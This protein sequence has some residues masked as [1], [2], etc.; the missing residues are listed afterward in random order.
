[1][2]KKR[3]FNF[4]EAEELFKRIIEKSPKYINA[5]VNYGN[6]KRDLNKYEDSNG[7]YK[8]ALEIDEKTPNCSLLSCNEF[9]IYG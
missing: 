7:L 2:L 6:L 8:K 5:Y 3:L 4:N 9:P 1:M